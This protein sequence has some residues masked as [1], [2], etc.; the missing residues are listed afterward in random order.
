M[1]QVVFCGDFYYVDR[2][3]SYQVILYRG[4]VMDISY[5]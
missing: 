1:F 2:D 4:D 5:E 3:Y